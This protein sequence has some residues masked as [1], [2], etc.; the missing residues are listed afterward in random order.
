VAWGR[1]PWGIRS[2]GASGSVIVD[3]P[4]LVF[5][6]LPSTLVHRGGGVKA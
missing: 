6:V 2:R 4:P 3:I 5:A 1:R